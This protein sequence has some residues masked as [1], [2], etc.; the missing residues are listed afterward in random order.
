MNKD[1]LIKNPRVIVEGFY[2]EEGQNT[3][4]YD[5]SHQHRYQ[6]TI[7]WLSKFKIE[8]Q[9]VCDMGCGTG[10]VLKQLSDNNTAIGIDGAKFESCDKITRYQANFDYDRFSEMIPVSDVNHMLCFETFEH[11]TNPYNFILECKKM[12]KPNG[13][14]HITYPT[15]T[16][17]HNTF[18]PSLLWPKNNF[19]QFMEQMAFELVVSMTMPTRFGGVHAFTFRNKSWENI[20]MKFPKD[21]EYK[22]YPP[23]VQVNI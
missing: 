23:H 15:L 22:H 4:E 6:N 20:K 17:Q 2:D 12:I 14:Y 11:L 8:N 9:V 21:D 1:D 7:K 13:Y 18:Y 3:S 16:I 19:I 10:F 5:E